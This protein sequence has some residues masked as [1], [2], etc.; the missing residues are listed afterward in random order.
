M[1]RPSVVILT[2]P[3][4]CELADG[5]LLLQALVQA[6][7]LS[8]EGVPV[9]QAFCDNPAAAQSFIDAYASAYPELRLQSPDLPLPEQ[10]YS[11]MVDGRLAP[12][13]NLDL[14]PD[15]TRPDSADKSHPLV[16]LSLGAPDALMEALPGNRF[17]NGRMNVIEIA[18]RDQSQS[19]SI[20]V[21]AAVGARAIAESSLSPDTSTSSA[22]PDNEQ[23]APLEVSSN[24]LLELDS[25]ELSLGDIQ[26]DQN[27]GQAQ[28]D[29]PATAILDTAPVISAAGTSATHRVHAEAP[30]GDSGN[31][32]EPEAQTTPAHA[33][34]I[35][36]AA[37]TEV[38]GVSPAAV[39]PIV[40]SDDAETSPAE[41]VAPLNPPP[42]TDPET[43]PQSSGGGAESPGSTSMESGSG[44]SLPAAAQVSDDP[45]ET[46]AS[47][48]TSTADP[49]TTDLDE[50][51]LAHGGSSFDGDNDV[52]YPPTGSLT[53]DEDV[54]Y[55]LPLAAAPGPDDLS[56]ILCRSMADDIVDLEAISSAG[57]D[58]A[59]MTTEP[60]DP[61]L[62]GAGGPDALGQHDFHG[63]LPQSPDLPRLDQ[64]TPDH[65]NHQ[66]ET[67]TPVH[68]LDI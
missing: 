48:A 13:P 51:D 68:D 61:I 37:G 53:S 21:A 42:G 11:M 30:V 58:Y 38:T 7:E 6:Q 19:A 10:L 59:V 31:A 43:P 24:A 66:D 15:G 27:R 60:F 29:Q 20:P 35:L 28:R 64:A 63:P 34:T 41:G 32:M 12:L 2:E 46:A 56:G 67:I 33:P 25:A 23:G 14:A 55:P 8:A 52:L 50:D 17:A 9:S 16:V 54:F 39:E 5:Q 22:F 47:L 1:T 3:A 57:A 65:D 4:N 45:G 44:E 40:V 26:I 49:D 18:P 36:T 62:T